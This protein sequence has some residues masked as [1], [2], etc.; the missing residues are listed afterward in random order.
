VL[1]I[2][3]GLVLLIACANGGHGQIRNRRG[4]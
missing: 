4:D 1:M 3:V 2:M